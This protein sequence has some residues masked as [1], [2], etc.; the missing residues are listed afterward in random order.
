MPA[1]ACTAYV[2]NVERERFLAAG[3]EGYVSKPFTRAGLLEA[4]ERVLASE[5]EVVITP[6]NAPEKQSAMERVPVSRT[7][8]DRVLVNGRVL[9]RLA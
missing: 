6:K 4:M 8:P 9:R 3:F 7:E 5:T 2:R 1:V